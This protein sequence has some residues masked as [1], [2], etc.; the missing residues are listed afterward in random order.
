MSWKLVV[1]VAAVRVTRAGACI[2]GVRPR[3]LKDT[4]NFGLSFIHVFVVDSSFLPLDPI[5][6]FELHLDELRLLLL[7]S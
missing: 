5:A 1:I 4:A 7:V 3:L 2:V 6:G